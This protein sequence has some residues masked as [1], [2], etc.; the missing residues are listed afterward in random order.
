MDIFYLIR[1]N[2]T[3]FISFMYID[4]CWACVEGERW[5]REAREGG[6]EAMDGGRKKERENRRYQNG[7]RREGE[8]W[9][10][11]VQRLEESRKGGK[12]G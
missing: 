4:R 9:E 6:G 2:R 3:S 11:R 8:K 12:R 1:G 5:E 7:L 10:K